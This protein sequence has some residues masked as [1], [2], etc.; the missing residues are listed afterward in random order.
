MLRR[1]E[2]NRMS[3]EIELQCPGD[4]KRFL[5]NSDSVQFRDLQS[6]CFNAT[7][8]CEVDDDCCPGLSCTKIG[9]RNSINVCLDDT[10]GE[11]SANAGLTFG[12]IFL[13]GFILLFVLWACLRVYEVNRFEESLSRKS[14]GNTG[15]TMQNLTTLNE[16]VKRKSPKP[17]KLS[18][19]LNSSN[20]RYKPASQV[21][22]TIEQINVGSY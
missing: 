22:S 17:K 14:H 11:A 12:L 5:E 1:T 15:T 9:S 16:T 20:K 18:S 6:N 7:F 2:K 8:S 4:G 10:V 3:A 13:S 21:P 19:H